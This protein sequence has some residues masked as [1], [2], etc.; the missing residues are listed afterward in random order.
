MIRLILALLIQ[1]LGFT[2]E[3]PRVDLRKR[4]PVINRDGALFIIGFIV[5]VVVFFGIVFLAQ[6][7]ETGIVRNNLQN[8]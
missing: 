4:E 1:A 3:N 7:T 2:E 5:L 6:G 8:I